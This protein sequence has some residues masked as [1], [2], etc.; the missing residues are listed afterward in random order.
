[1]FFCAALWRPLEG[2]LGLL[3]ATTYK[4]EDTVCIAHVYIIR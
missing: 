2:A 3:I 4:P 1:M